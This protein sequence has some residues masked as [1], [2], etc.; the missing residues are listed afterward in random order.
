MKKSL[1]ATTALVAAFGMGATA[2]QA[3]D[4]SFTVGGFSD[5]YATWVDQDNPGT[6][7]Y[8][9]GDGYH[10]SDYDFSTNTELLF[11]GEITLDNGI[12]AGMSV[13]VEAD[14][15]DG[16]GERDNIDENIVY[17]EGSF[18]RVELG[19]E[20]G[21]HDT[22]KY[23]ATS[24]KAVYPGGYNNTTGA[25]YN[26]SGNAAP[27]TVN[28]ND[29]GDSTKI[30]YYTPRFAGF[31]LGVTHAPD[32][33]ADAVFPS[34][35]ATET[36]DLWEGGANYVNSF[37]SF[38]LAASL[39]GATKNVA[40]QGDTWGITGGAVLGFAGFE[41]GG[42][43]GFGETDDEDTMA[44][45]LGVA[46]STGPWSISLTGYYAS[47]DLA[48]GGEDERTEGQ[49]G[50]NY[51]LGSGVNVYTTGVYGQLESENVDDNDYTTLLAGVG[52]SF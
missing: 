46:Y 24:I 25:F 17:L 19:H 36:T 2:A 13:Q 51:A 18:G 6:S 41:F 5:F 35:D 42:A 27:I 52:V 44:G 48:G 45:D 9:A 50:L 4:A 29:S 38:D 33:N 12:T 3:Q 10:E 11:N 16:N 23:G 43:Y 15:N 30:N 20:D 8:T 14:N 7:A 49:L 32:G 21:A 26:L 39:T 31:Q 47:Q 28:F 1:F 22:M 34:R 40:N 37:G